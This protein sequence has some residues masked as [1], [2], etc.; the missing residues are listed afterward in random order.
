MLSLTLDELTQRAEKIKLVISDNDGVFTDNGVY[1]S[2]RGEEMK[3]YSIRDGMG[4]ERLRNSGIETSIMTGEVSPSLKKRAEKLGMRRL[5][6]GVK[7]KFSMLETVLAET[8]LHRYELAYI[9]DDVND[10]EIMEE[11]AREGLTA[12]PR[13]ATFFVE[14]FIHYRAQA[15][16][17]YGAFRDFAEWLLALRNS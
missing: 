3:R 4:V 14:P 13:D 7:D 12:S 8:G 9:G 16:G 17:G 10:V 2:E 6:L 11:I 1:Y 15:D 5:Y